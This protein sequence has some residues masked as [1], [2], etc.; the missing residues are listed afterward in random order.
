MKFNTILSYF[1]IIIFAP[2]LGKLIR[3]IILCYK[4]YKKLNSDLSLCDLLHRLTP[5]EF[6]I[7]CSE[8]LNTLGFNNILVTPIGPDGGKDII[9]YKNNEKYY[10]ECKRYS[11]NNLVSLEHVEKLLGAMIADNI[12]NGIII[13]T[14][15][16]S[17][18][19]KEFLHSLKKPYCIQIISASELNESYS[20]YNIQ[21]N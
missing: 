7:W 18:D 14:S 16:I 2:L 19:A 21:T 15:T 10:V 9:C 6:E 4:S 12:N 1:T 17:D 13:T 3:N 8:Y 20:R 11:S 5:H